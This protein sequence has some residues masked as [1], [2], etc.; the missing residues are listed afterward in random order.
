[1]GNHPS[2]SAQFVFLE[3]V[4]PQ[5]VFH[6]LISAANEL[7][8]FSLIY[9]DISPL[10]L[11]FVFSTPR[12]GWLDQIDIQIKTSAL[13]CVVEASSRSTNVCPG[14]CGCMRAA[15]SEFT[16]YDDWGQNEAH[17]ITL[18]NQLNISYDRIQ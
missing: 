4:H 7:P 9:Q 18:L 3:P 6:N 2:F 12:C 1:M 10:S 13:E 14:W 11:R 16:C 8:H 17:V 5:E 15:C